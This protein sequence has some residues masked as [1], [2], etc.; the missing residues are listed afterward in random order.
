MNFGVVC[1]Y[2]ISSTGFEY[3]KGMFKTIS[4]LHVV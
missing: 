3:A 1:N 4:N 2:S